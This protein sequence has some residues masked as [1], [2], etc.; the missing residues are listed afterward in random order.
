M[1]NESFYKGFYGLERETLRIKNHGRL[2]LTPHPFSRNESITRDYCENQIEIITPVCESIDR[3]MVSL[4]EL[5]KKVRKELGKSGEDL[6]LM[7][8]T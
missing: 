6:H 3:L 2:A 8:L 7:T 1:I 5:D 4:E